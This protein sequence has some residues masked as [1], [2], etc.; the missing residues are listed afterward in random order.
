[1]QHSPAPAPGRS[2]EGRARVEGRARFEARVREWFVANAPRK[3]SPEDFS[4]VHVVSAR[5]P[6]EYHEQEQHAITV[7]RAW[8]RRLFDAGL[9]G[10]SWPTECG[11]HGAPG[12]QDE[13]VVAEQAKWGVSTK[14]FAVA[15][16]MVPA[17]LFGHGTHEQRVAYLPPILRGEH[18]W[19]QLLSEPG[20]GSDLA[21]AQ[22]RATPVDGG[23]SVT[24]QKVWTSNAG[25]SD[26]ALLIAR[27]GSREE[28]RAGLSCFAM[29]M[30]QPGVEI[31]PLRQM[32]GAYHFN[33]VF[34]DNAFVPE[35]GLI[36][37]PREGWAVLRTMLASERAAIGGGTSA[38]SATQLVGLARQLGCSDDPGVRDLLAQAV[39]RERTLDLLRARIAAGH[40]V[41]AA[42]P[43]TKLLYSEHARLSADA[44]TTILGMAVTLVD[45]P[46]AAPWIER[47]LFAPG[48]RLGG[49]TDEI[50]RNTIAERGLGLPR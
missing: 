36:G 34:L 37:G 2:G 43:T 24:G 5:T 48:L 21:S 22:T 17:V 3:G 26:Y 35:N 14:M 31:R 10:R 47:L 39:I 28:G 38:R 25:C 12:W 23:W 42:G 29:K 49:G 19:C 18:G 8:Q 15:L 9:A 1:M 7:T 40:A 11:G 33:E 30:E 45:D 44:A 20:A 41:P 50:Q 46:Q 13:V 6:Q 16:E 4:A 27:T 32:S